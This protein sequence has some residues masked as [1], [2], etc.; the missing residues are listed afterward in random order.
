VDA[1]LDLRSDT[2][3]IMTLLLT[4]VSAKRLVQRRRWGL[5]FFASG[6]DLQGI[7]YAHEYYLRRIASVTQSAPPP[8]PQALDNART[9]VA[10][11]YRRSSRGP[12]ASDPILLCPGAGSPARQWPVERWRQLANALA[13]RGHD[14]WIAPGQPD[15]RSRAD[16]ER[17]AVHRRATLRWDNSIE[18]AA[19]LL[20]SGKLAVT[21]DSAMSHLAFLVRTPVITLFGPSDP[22]IWYPYSLLSA[23]AFVTP[24]TPRDCFPCQ[25]RRCAIAQRCIDEIDLQTVLGIVDNRLSS[26]FPSTADTQLAPTK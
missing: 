12:Q 18:E 9:L 15:A 24:P 26:S 2:V 14:V 5:G 8:L 25:R 23:G 3:S 19:G 11:S 4:N 1:V 21:V 10:A 6:S 17:A 20:A 13:E 22:N 7:K 16:W